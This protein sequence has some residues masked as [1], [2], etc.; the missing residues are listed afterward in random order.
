MR[1]VRKTML[2]QKRLLSIGYGHGDIAYFSIAYDVYFLEDSVRHD[3]IEI[4]SNWVIRSSN[5]SH[6]IFAQT[7][8]VQ[9]SSSMPLS[10]V[11]VPS[12]FEFAM[13]ISKLMKAKQNSLI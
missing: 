8:H 5:R 7:A 1:R 6:S 4:E 10:N 13:N 2:F 12:V 11:R 3:V 9:C